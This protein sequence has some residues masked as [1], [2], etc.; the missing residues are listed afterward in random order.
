MSKPCLVL[1]LVLQKICLVILNNSLPPSLFSECGD[2]TYGWRC[3][4]TC[5]NCSNGEPCHHV[6][7]TCPFGCDAGVY[8]KKCD[9]GSTISLSNVTFET[10]VVS[11]SITVKYFFDSLYWTWK[12]T[13]SSS[14]ST[15]NWHKKMKL[16]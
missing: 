3:Q 16:E 8:G 5:G 4:Q 13:T 1:C 2:N 9:I 12:K 11:F 15:S 6:N 14:L 10:T 7:G